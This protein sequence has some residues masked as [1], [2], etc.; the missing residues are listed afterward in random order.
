MEVLIKQTTNGYVTQVLCDPDDLC[1]GERSSY[2]TSYIDDETKINNPHGG[3]RE[4]VQDLI[5]LFGVQGTRYDKARL[6]LTYVEG[7]KHEDTL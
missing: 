2:C 4:L 7:D 6:H 1:E 5:D 3:F